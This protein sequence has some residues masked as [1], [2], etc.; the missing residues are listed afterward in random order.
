MIKQF[1]QKCKEIRSSNIT[2]FT[3]K[4]HQ[5]GFEIDKLQAWSDQITEDVDAIAINDH[6]DKIDKLIDA[7]HKNH[8]TSGDCDICNIPSFEDLFGKP[9]PLAK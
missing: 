2:G 9:D 3:E 7:I 5:L 4:I 8:F 6:Y 1:L